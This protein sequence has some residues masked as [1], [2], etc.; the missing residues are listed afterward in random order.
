MIMISSSVALSDE[1]PVG[2]KL[3][4]IKN[5][6]YLAMPIFN[7]T[8]FVFFG[9]FSKGLTFYSQFMKFI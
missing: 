1:F 7:N 9:L 3:Q 2:I 4:D 8:I 6:I 5:V